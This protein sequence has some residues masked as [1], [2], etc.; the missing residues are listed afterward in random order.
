MLRVLLFVLVVACSF[1]KGRAQVIKSVKVFTGGGFSFLR[2]PKIQ[3]E[4]YR[5]S[6]TRKSDDSA[7]LFQQHVIN[8]VYYRS[9]KNYGFDF[10]VLALVYENKNFQIETGISV[11]FYS[12]ERTVYR[13]YKVLSERN[14]TFYFPQGA[15]HLYPDEDIR[16]VGLLY[17]KSVR[18]AFTQLELPV[19]AVHKVAGLNLGY[20]LIPVL[21]LSSQIEGYPLNDPE[22]V[23][24]SD[25][26]N[27]SVVN[28]GTSLS[29][30]K[31]VSKKMEIGI[32]YKYQFG[33]SV[34]IQDE[35]KGFLSS[36]NFLLAYRIAIKSKN[37]NGE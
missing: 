4:G 11:G 5:N 3:L 23:F 19:R 33:N 12:L 25:F 31:N 13:K 16:V 7:D 1:Q 21:L 30:S 2:V 27:R 35:P 29:V 36:L 26:K 14:A 22:F 9:R 10:G 15:R 28:F 6:V 32:R 34:K 24:T 20:E 18:L 17:F 8:T 37:I